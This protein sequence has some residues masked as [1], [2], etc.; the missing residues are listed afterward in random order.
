[1]FERIRK[2]LGQA[3]PAK[4]VGHVSPTAKPKPL[5]YQAVSIRPAATGACNAAG[6]LA[7]VRFLVAEAPLLPLKT[8]DAATCDC[9]YVRFSDRRADARRVVD[10]SISQQ[11]DLR[12][13]R[14]SDRGRRKD[15]HLFD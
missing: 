14:R 13:D 6:Q 3:E 4:P 1:M 11:I 7:S 12:N 8:C 9:K 2:L 5:S 15:D 10:T